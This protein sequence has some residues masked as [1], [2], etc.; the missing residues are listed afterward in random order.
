MEQ[1]RPIFIFSLPRSGST[2]LQRI[3]AAHG[4]I[5]T[6]TEPWLLLPLFYTFRSDGVASEYGHRLCSK[7][8]G[9]FAAGLP[10]GEA[11]YRRAINS[12]AS[13]LYGEAA[14]P[15]AQYFVD[16]TP[17]YSLVVGEIMET[18][19]DAKFLF[20]WRNP[21]AVISSLITTYGRDH[22]NVVRFKLELFNGLD[23][24]LRAHRKHGDTSFALRFEDLTEQPDTV[25]PQVFEYLELPYDASVQRNFSQVALDGGHGDHTGTVRYDKLST[26]P[27]DKW[28]AVLTNTFRKRWSRRYL[29]WLG[30][31]RLR[32]M[33]YELSD[34]M[35]DLGNVRDSREYLAADLYIYAKQSLVA[36]LQW[37]LVRQRYRLRREGRPLVTFN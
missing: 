27:V 10:D 26:E 30:E 9:E 31:D 2:L 37:Q 7:A 14:D 4:R 36:L 22:F 17:I 18:F 28:K 25:L 35:K 1:I 15:T 20:L 5:A 11:S 6:T 33:G 29:A 34:L 3:L 16:K 8:I 23:N 13:Q 19:P 12:F 32:A 24:L 21:L